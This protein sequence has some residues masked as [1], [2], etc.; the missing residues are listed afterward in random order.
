MKDVKPI[1][2]QDHYAA[3]C[4]G[5]NSISF[6]QNKKVKIK[7]INISTKGKKDLKEIYYFSIA[8]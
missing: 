2:M 1:G 8:E 6:Y 4:G 3:S 7:K 5:M